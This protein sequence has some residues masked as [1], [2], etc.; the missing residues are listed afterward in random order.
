MQHAFLKIPFLFLVFN[1]FLAVFIVPFRFYFQGGGTD[2]GDPPFLIERV[3]TISSE[4][5]IML[6][7]EGFDEIRRDM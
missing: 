1:S 3:L 2:L 4:R 7:G 5:M 6:E